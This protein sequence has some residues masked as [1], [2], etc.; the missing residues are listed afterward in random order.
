MAESTIGKFACYNQLTQF[1]N[2]H[3]IFQIN[4]AVV[5]DHFES[6]T[7]SIDFINQETTTPELFNVDVLPEIQPHS[8]ISYDLRELPPLSLNSTQVNR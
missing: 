2:K 8:A 3:C 6:T 7:L 1:K 5:N 4:P